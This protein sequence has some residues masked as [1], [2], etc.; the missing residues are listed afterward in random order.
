[1]ALQASFPSECLDKRGA[2]GSRVLAGA[3][4]SPSLWLVLGAWAPLLLL[5]LGQVRAAKGLTLL[6]VL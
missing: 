6:G 3:P 2:L 1:M 5:V 4:L